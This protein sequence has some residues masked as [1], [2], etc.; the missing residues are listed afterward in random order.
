MP[1]F[2]EY[3]V[4]DPHAWLDGD[5]YCSI[6]GNN[7]LWPGKRATLWKSKDLENWQLVGDF[8]HHDGPPHHLDC[9]D[10]FKLGNRYVL[11]Y[12]GDGLEYSVYMD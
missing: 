7:S 12:L 1:T 4:W 6:S 5:T 3:D 10:F 2:G 8:F 9:P 11:I